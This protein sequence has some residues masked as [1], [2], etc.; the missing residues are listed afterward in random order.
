MKDSKLLFSQPVNNLVT[1]GVERDGVLSHELKV[2][3][4]SRE[5]INRINERL[6]N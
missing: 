2:R 4:V 3:I 1:V 5:L 6:K